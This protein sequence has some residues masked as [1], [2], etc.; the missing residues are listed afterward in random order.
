MRISAEKS[1]WILAK[2]FFFWRSPNFGRKKAL[3]FGFRPKNHSEYRRRPFFFFLEITY[4]WAEKTFEFPS[5]PRHFVSSFGQTVWNWFKINEN[6]SQDRLHTSYSFKIA[7]PFPNPGYAPVP[8]CAKMEHCQM[9]NW[10]G[11]VRNFLI[12]NR[13]ST[14]WAMLLLRK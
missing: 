8:K 6:S 9:G 3:N 12:V 7:P 13:R 14:N 2:T 10:K 5:F 11:G 1:L 4:F